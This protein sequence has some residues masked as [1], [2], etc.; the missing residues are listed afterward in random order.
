MDSYQLPSLNLKQFVFF[1]K[2]KSLLSRIKIIIT[3]NIF[4]TQAELL[5]GCKLLSSFDEA[6]QSDFTD[7]NLEM[8]QLRIY[9]AKYYSDLLGPC[10][11]FKDRKRLMLI[12]HYEQSDHLTTISLSEFIPDDF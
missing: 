3:S 6:L 10:L 9:I 4:L 7:Y 1:H 11:S 8:E 12:E 5:Y 2:R